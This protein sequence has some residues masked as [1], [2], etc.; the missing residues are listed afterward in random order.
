LQRVQG[1]TVYFVG[2]HAPAING[3]ELLTRLRDVGAA[4]DVLLSAIAAFPMTGD[5]ER[6]L[7]AG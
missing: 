1:Q 2:T 4:Q 3:Y 5:H 7:F 6:F